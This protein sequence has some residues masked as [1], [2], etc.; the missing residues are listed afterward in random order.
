MLNKLFVSLRMPT[1][2]LVMVIGALSVPTPASA[3]STDAAEAALL[4]DETGVVE[5]AYTGD[6][7][8]AFHFTPNLACDAPT[9]KTTRVADQSQVSDSSV[10]CRPAQPT[11]SHRICYKMDVYAFATATGITVG[12]GVVTGACLATGPVAACPYTI[13]GFCT[14]TSLG[15]TLDPVML[16]RNV[17]SAQGTGMVS[18]TYRCTPHFV[19][20]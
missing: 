15:A 11:G 7:I 6:Q 17:Y 4:A 9:A 5:V 18:V 2:V 12:A 19:Y 13:P 8:T 20:V 14:A 3:R 16:C 10:S 1:I